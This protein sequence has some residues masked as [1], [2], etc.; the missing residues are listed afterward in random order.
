[1]AANIRAVYKESSIPAPTLKF[2]LIVK[3]G[4]GSGTYEE[5]EVVSIQANAPVA[6]MEF[7]RWKTNSGKVTFDNYKSIN[8]TVTIL[9]SNAE[10]E[11]LYK[12]IVPVHTHTYGKWSYDNI[13]HWQECTDPACPNKAY[14]IKYQGYHQFSTSRDTTCNVCGY[15][16]TLPTYNFIDGTNG[17]WIKNSG[18]DLGFKA[19]GEFSKF[20]GVKVDGTLIGADKYTAVTGSTL[21]TLKKD[22]LETLSVGKHTLTVVYID[23]ECTT[24][25]EVK[26]KV[27]EKPGTEEDKKPGTDVEKPITPEEDKNPGTDAEKPGKEDTKPSTNTEKPINSKEDKKTDVKSEKKK[28]LNT[29]YSEN[30]GQ[31]MA[32]LLMSGFVLVLSVFKKK[33]N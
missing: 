30:M 12:K 14:T 6:G 16:R 21:V 3:N 19:D 31:W 1:M 33:R 25:F 9:D 22:Y 17:E 15:K 7:D 27:V 24:E 10:I 18:K 2:D 8:T 26:N 4:T 11:A 13:G 28:S 20:T 23:G 5:N 32:L 29:A